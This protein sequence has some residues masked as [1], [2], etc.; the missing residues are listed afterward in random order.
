MF[1]HSLLLTTHSR[2][3]RFNSI[4]AVRW[5]FWTLTD[6]CFRYEKQIQTLK[7]C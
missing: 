7:G 6:S 2:S 1:T 4:C 3:L 5:A